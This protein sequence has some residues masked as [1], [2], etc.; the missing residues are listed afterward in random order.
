MIYKSFN[1]L[2]GHCRGVWLIFLI[3]SFISSST[4][5]DATKITAKQFFE[6]SPEKRVNFLISKQYYSGSEDAYRAEFLDSLAKFPQAS[7]DVRLLLYIHVFRLAEL[8]DHFQ[9][10]ASGIQAFEKERNRLGKSQFPDV[11]GLYYLYYGQ[12]YIRFKKR[13]DGFKLLLTSTKELERIGFEN[14][15]FGGD[16]LHGFGI[17]YYTAG[18]YDLAIKYL[19]R[20]VNCPFVLTH[21]RIN[22]VHGLGYCY[23][24]ENIRDYAKA[25]R[26]FAQSYN[27]ARHYKDDIMTFAS[28]GDYARALQLQGRNKEA[29][30][31]L[32]KCLQYAN[33][34]ENFNKSVFDLYKAEILL[35][36]NKPDLAKDLIEESDSLITLCRP[37]QKRR[38]LPDYFS[39][40][41]MLY[42]KT[43]RFDKVLAY[44]DSIIFLKDS[45]NITASNR[46]LE[47]LETGVNAERYFLALSAI[48]SARRRDIYISIFYLACFLLIGAIIVYGFK[49]RKR[50]L[51]KENEL[52]QRMKEVV[53]QKAIRTMQLRDQQLAQLKE[54]NALI[55]KVNS[56]LS[57]LRRRSET[58]AEKKEEAHGH[59]DT[60][61]NSV[62]ITDADWE[63]FQVLFEKIHP[64]FLEKINS[65][66][67]FL[68]P[69]EMRLVALSKLN[70]PSRE[71]AVMLGLTKDTIYTFKYRLRKKLG[72]HDAD[73]A[74]LTGRL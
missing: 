42:R 10:L 3:T 51:V 56:E 16:Y 43:G 9:D 2:P 48:K 41:S 14:L 59:I 52:N 18:Y 27:M 12:Y 28:M 24:S 26:Y 32:D 64:G 7:E 38:R 8:R 13:D 65:K 49:Q 6:L 57:Q 46:I 45:I 55:E 69:S 15:P 73:F 47:E 25:A 70:I 11:R 17:Y 37:D 22:A 53:E 35:V 71:M 62:I 60:L 66:Y 20:A 50:E 31:Y 63:E 21:G 39:V 58:W 74:D 23:K 68:T 1:F 67:S 34:A 5:G 61:L 72:S 54:K 33:P 36:Y 30:V 44:N 40:M 4:Y 29:L 19:N